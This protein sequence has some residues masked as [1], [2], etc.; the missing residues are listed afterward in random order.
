[1]AT[2]LCRFASRAGLLRLRNDKQFWYLLMMW[3]VQLISGQTIA[4]EGA[5]RFEVDD[6]LITFVTDDDEEIACFW[7]GYVVGV[8]PADAR[9]KPDAPMP[10]E[11]S[12]PSEQIPQMDNGDEEDEEED[13]P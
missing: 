3:Q 2:P 1:V 8:Y 13:E 7:S 12:R 5:V 9:V 4:F 6:D 11:P 10:V